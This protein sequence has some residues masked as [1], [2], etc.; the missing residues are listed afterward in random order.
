MPPGAGRDPRPG[1]HADRP[2]RRD[3]PAG[4]PSRGCGRLPHQAVLDAGT[5]RPGPRRAAAHGEGVP[6][7][8]GRPTADRRRRPGDQPGRAPGAPGRRRGAPDPDGVRPSGAP[9]QAAA[10]GAAAGTS[11][12]RHLGLGR[13]IGD[14]HGRQP[15]QGA[16][17]QAG[18]RPDPHRARRRLRPGDPGRGGT[19]VRPAKIMDLLPRPLDP[20][21]SIKLKLGMLLVAAGLAGLVVFRIGIGW[22]PYATSFTAIVVA[23]ATSQVLAHGMTSPLRDLTA[24]A[25]AMAKGDYSRR[26]RATSRDEVGQ[27]AAAFNSMAE[28]LALADKQRRELIANVSH[29]LRTPITALQA[30]LE[31]II[32]GVAD[33]DT[34][35]TALGQ[36]ERLGRLVT[37]LLDL[38]RID[39]G[40]LPLHRAPVT[41]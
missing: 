7:R 22:I 32:D 5:D 18:R 10:G 34:L 33:P 8:F 4:G 41:L 14:A 40:V 28:D 35:K 13:R 20:V 30:V 39:A 27:L 12:R 1:D 31:N 15:H 26:V 17:P 2:G 16:A 6:G 19:A 25:R 21:R 38:S 3:R 37:E 24:A 29:E 36:T 23:L 11:A 9:G